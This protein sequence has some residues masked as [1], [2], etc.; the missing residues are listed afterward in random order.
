MKYWIFKKKID[1]KR[2]H[3]K[4]KFTFSDANRMTRIM[5]PY[6]IY[7]NGLLKHWSCFWDEGRGGTEEKAS[8]MTT[9]EGMKDQDN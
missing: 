5:T 9:I 3:L 1:S 4:H 7:K 2:W 6:C 8:P